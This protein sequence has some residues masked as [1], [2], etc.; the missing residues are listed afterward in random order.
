MLLVFYLQLLSGSHRGVDTL[1]PKI[2]LGF[3][4][5]SVIIFYHCYPRNKAVQFLSLI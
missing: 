4:K 3:A 1:L 2:H 5:F